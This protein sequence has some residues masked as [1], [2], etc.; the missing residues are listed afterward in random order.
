VIFAVLANSE[1]YQRGIAL[2]QTNDLFELLNRLSDIENKYS[3]SLMLFNY[4]RIDWYF[5]NN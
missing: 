1:I 3:I 4:Q 2:G 5:N